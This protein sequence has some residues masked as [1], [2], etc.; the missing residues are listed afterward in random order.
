[1]TLRRRHSG[2][3]CVRV[4]HDNRRCWWRLTFSGARWAVS[5]LSDPAVIA[6]RKSPLLAG[7]V[8]SNHHVA[9]LLPQLMPGTNTKPL[10]VACVLGGVVLPVTD[11]RRRQLP[12]ARCQLDIGA[13]D[14]WPTNQPTNQHSPTD[15]NTAAA[16][17]PLIRLITSQYLP[18]RHLQLPIIVV[19]L[20]L[21]IAARHA[22][23][24]VHYYRTAYDEM[25]AANNI[26]VSL[27]PPRFCVCLSDR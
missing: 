19:L 2:C 21:I 6:A 10:R 26:R 20:R 27:H 17:W 4:V 5:E 14:H 22:T 15:D 1:M 16:A 8:T 7:R 24:R 25:L 13:A 9:L 23:P 18:K 3:C 11:E 12:H